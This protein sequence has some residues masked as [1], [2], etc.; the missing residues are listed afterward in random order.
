M[1]GA[2]EQTKRCVTTILLILFIII[3]I[4]SC[5]E[6][7]LN[8][9]KWGEFWLNLGNE[10]AEKGDYSNAIE[11]YTNGIERDPGGKW[12]VLLYSK[13]AQAYEALEK[14]ADAISDRSLIINRGL[15]L[16]PF[17]FH[18]YQ[19]R[20]ETYLNLAEQQGDTDKA[21]VFLH[22]ALND[23]Y[24]AKETCYFDKEGL[25]FGSGLIHYYSGI[26]H[27]RLS[28][29]EPDHFRSALR[30]FNLLVKILGKQEI[31]AY[32]KLMPVVHYYRGV[33]MRKNC[34]YMYE[35]NVRNVRGNTER[36]Q[37]LKQEKEN[38]YKLAAAAFEQ[39]A[40]MGYEPAKSAL[41]R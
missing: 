22:K 13:R 30:D 9:E 14:Y 12:I 34:D 23:F 24:E 32:K 31:P 17:A 41:K 33:C 19:L 20:G 2:A 21:K 40:A 10:L 16:P 8:K 29:N 3:N 1:G 25:C 37:P 36:E 11:K 26:T 39:A 18:E 38:C 27:I 5:K 6:S 4:S 28:S 35:L 7:N 15:Y